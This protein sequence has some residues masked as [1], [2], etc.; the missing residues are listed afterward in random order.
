MNKHIIAMLLYFAAAAFF[1]L[2][3]FLDVNAIVVGA[4]LLIAAVIFSRSIKK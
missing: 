3:V 2:Y 4:V 1:L